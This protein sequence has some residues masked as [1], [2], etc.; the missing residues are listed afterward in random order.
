MDYLRIAVIVI[1]VIVIIA[2]IA[3]VWRAT[4]RS[5]NSRSASGSYSD[6]SHSVSGSGTADAHRFAVHAPR[7][8]ARYTVTKGK[9][10]EETPE[11][12]AQA[13][14]AQ[15]QQQEFPRHAAQAGNRTREQRILAQQVAD[16][17]IEVQAASQPQEQSERFEATADSATVV[18]VE[19]LAD[20]FSV[21]R[22]V[23][24]ELGVSEE[25]M[26]KMVAAYQKKSE[27]RERRLPV[28][29]HFNLDDYK[30]SKRVMRESA[31][32]AANFQGT[33]RGT[34]TNAIYKKYGKNF[35]KQGNGSN[36]D[37][38]SMDVDADRHEA[39]LAKVRERRANGYLE[40][41]T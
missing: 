18:T 9:L 1:M 11:V 25:E 5:D 41:R 37:V 29:Q 33:K 38:M 6:N 34:I 24:A 10:A 13:P 15:G 27:Y 31:N 23:E 2:V 3:M 30:D 32:T 4:R 16:S 21:K 8:Q 17:R 22:N 40:V 35:T 39:H 14:P 20:L 7:G 36:A 28:N 12:Q 26:Q 19:R